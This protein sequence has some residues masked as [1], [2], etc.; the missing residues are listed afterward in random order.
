MLRHCLASLTGLALLACAGGAHAATVCYQAFDAATGAPQA[1]FL[2]L[3]TRQA[4]TLV[5][6]NEGGTIGPAQKLVEVDGYSTIRTGRVANGRAVVEMA[7]VTGTA[8][9]VVGQGAQMSLWRNFGRGEQTLVGF[10]ALDCGSTSASSTPS[11]WTCRGATVFKGGTPTSA[12]DLRL[13]KVNAS[14]T[15]QC[16]EFGLRSN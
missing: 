8:L 15:P 13:G 10:S 6:A 7:I 4:G 3:Q 12:R 1:T 2:R 16:R 5:P 9:V 14:V 11:S